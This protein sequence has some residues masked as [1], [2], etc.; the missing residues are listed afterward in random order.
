MESL[1]IGSVPIYRVGG[2]MPHPFPYII[3]LSIL[4]YLNACPRDQGDIANLVRPTCYKVWQ[5][6]P[7]YMQQRAQRGHEGTKRT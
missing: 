1:Y 4:S 2:F 3:A 5:R 7:Q 6:P